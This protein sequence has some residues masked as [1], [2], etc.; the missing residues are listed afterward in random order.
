LRGGAFYPVLP[1]QISEKSG[2]DKRTES[3]R[4][5]E[6]DMREKLRGDF[7]AFMCPDGLVQNG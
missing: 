3:G 4:H 6:E 5:G 2:E 7:Q 1:S